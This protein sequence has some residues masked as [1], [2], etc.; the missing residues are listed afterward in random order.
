ML[1]TVAREMNKAGRLDPL[2]DPLDCCLSCDRLN[3]ASEA[4]RGG[5]RVN[6]CELCPNVPQSVHGRVPRTV[7]AYK[8]HVNV[9]GP[10]RWSLSLSPEQSRDGRS[11]RRDD[12]V[13]AALAIG[14]G[15]RVYARGVQWEEDKVA[16]RTP[17]KTGARTASRFLFQAREPSNA[18]SGRH[19]YLQ[20]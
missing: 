4:L 16:V 10:D 20:L 5:D 7:F 8:E 18:S 3:R 14:G 19:T 9:G 11:V 1:E 2:C 15:P 6:T 12:V 17:V 13:R